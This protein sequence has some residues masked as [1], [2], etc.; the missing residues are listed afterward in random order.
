MQPNFEKTMKKYIFIAEEGERQLIDKHLSDIN[1]EAEIVVTGVGAFNILKNLKDIPRDAEV[2]NIGYAGSSNFAI[3][4]V[5][6]VTESRLN[7]PQVNYPEPEYILKPIAIK[8]A[9][10][11][12]ICYSGTDFVTESKYRDCVFDME[13]AFIAGLG[14]TNLSAV[15]IVSDNLDLHA[16]HELT[17]GVE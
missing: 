10:Q 1:G 6:V 11:Q 15:K 3:G 14:F 13:L 2:I 17:N 9:T 4:S 16:Y 12:A 7:H 8:T 5:V